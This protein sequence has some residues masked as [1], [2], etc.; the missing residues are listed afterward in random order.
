MQ[1]I[2]NKLSKLITQLMI[3]ALQVLA[4]LH[5]HQ[6]L[7]HP[8]QVQAQAPPPVPAHQGSIIVT[9]LNLL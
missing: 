5:H 1:Y 2:L 6:V 7:V 3:S 4:L 8:A 9:I